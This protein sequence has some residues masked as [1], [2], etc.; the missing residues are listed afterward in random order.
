M[1]FEFL[2]KKLYIIDYI[3]NYQFFQD[4]NWPLDKN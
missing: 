3:P 2:I 1:V 4:K